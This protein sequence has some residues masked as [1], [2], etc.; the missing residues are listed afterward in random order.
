MI[1]KHNKRE[2]S[3]EKLSFKAKKNISLANYAKSNGACVKQ[4]SFGL[5]MAL[6]IFIL[7][8]KALIEHF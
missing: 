2:I 1:R 5:N 8:M 6:A 7:K 3:D 4:L